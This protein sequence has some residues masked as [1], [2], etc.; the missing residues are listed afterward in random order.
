MFIN[1]IYK[2]HKNIGWALFH[3]VLESEN[4]TELPSQACE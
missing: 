2:I 1:N 4:L 3:F